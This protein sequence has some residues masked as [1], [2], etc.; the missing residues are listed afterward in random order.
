MEI[1]PPFGM[2]FLI[3]ALPLLI[4]ITAFLLVGLINRA[5]QELGFSPLIAFF[6]IIGVLLGSVINIPVGN[7]RGMKEHHTYDSSFPPRRVKIVSEG[8]TRLSINVGG[9]IIPVTISVFLLSR[10]DERLYLPLLLATAF[11]ASVCYK[12][13]KPVENRGIA[14]PALVPPVVA[15][16]VALLISPHNAA[17]IAFISG[18]IGVL[19]GADLMNIGKIRRVA[20]SISIGGAGTFDGIFLTGLLS[21]LLVAIA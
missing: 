10:M 11:V 7:I 6:L 21:V 8:V 13:A 19:I 16:L 1:K 14:M 2:F 3:M 20:A 17:P 9:A 5:F 12:L 18:V 4:M 15:S